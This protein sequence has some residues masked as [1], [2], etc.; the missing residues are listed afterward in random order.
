MGGGG[1]SCFRKA[2]FFGGW[3]SKWPTIFSKISLLNWRFPSKE[4]VNFSVFLIGFEF[5]ALYFPQ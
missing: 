3:Q 1:P 5:K 2:Q 4:L